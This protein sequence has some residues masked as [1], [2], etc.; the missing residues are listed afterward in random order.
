MPDPVPSLPDTER[1]TRYSGLS[2]NVG[3][4]SVGFDLYGSS[5]DYA[6]WVE[7]WLSGV[8]LVSGTDY[9]LDSPSGTLSALA[10]PITDARVTPAGAYA[11]GFTG[12]LDIV[13]AFR[14][15]RATQLTE[16]QGEP[17][18]S[19]NQTYTTIIAGLR[20]F[21]DKFARVTQAPP[22][23]TMNVLAAAATRASRYAKFDSSGHLTHGETVTLIESGAVAAAQSATDAAASATAAASSASAASTSASNAST[24]ASN[25]STSASNAATSATAAGAAVAAVAFKFTWKTDQTATDPT[26]GGVK[27]NAAPGSATALYISET[28]ANGNAIAAEI[29]RWDD[30]TNAAGKARVKIAKDATNFLLLT[31]TSNVTDQGAWD[32]FTVSGASLTGTLANNDTVYVTVDTAGSDGGGLAN[33]VE[34]TTPQLGGTLD[35]NSKQV[36]FSKGADVASA[37]ALVLGADGNYFDITGTTAITSIGTL[38]VGSV[39]K[40]HFDGALTLTHHATDLILPGGANITTAAGDE[41]EF[42]EYAAGDWICTNYSKADPSATETVEGLV[43]L[44]TAAETTTGTDASRA[45]TP[46]GLAGS[47]YGKTVV[48]ILVFDDS[49]DCVTGDGAGDVFWRVPA[50]L[51]GYNLV[52]VAAQVQTAGTTNTM[53]IQIARIRSG[54][55]ADML[56][57]KI[58]IDSTEIDTATAA[59]PAVINGANDDVATGDQIRIDV[60]AVHTTKAKGLMVELTFQLP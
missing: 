10:R 41:A 51:N 37:N 59:T 32:S 23:E 6:Q 47:D 53:D 7:V 26:S 3:P 33:V 35:T 2:S 46:D 56:S 55:P 58:T 40:L 5:T 45:V 29:A 22:G 21:W 1:R 44:A 14:P 25:A 34:D 28:D 49:Q 8:K 52:A 4:F 48:S 57:T 17:A 9:T 43:E 24:S 13:G 11:A 54:T 36:Q 18:R 60:D 16:G 30:P 42:V 27:V 12:T 50:V 31:I 38:K 15:R 19:A 20:E 39:V